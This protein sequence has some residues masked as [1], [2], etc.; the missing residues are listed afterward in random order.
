MK[1]FFKDIKTL[2]IL[3]LILIVLFLRFCS[4]TNP[5]LLPNP[6]PPVVVR[7]ETKWDTITRI[8]PIYTPKWETKT[9]YRDTTIY[10]DVDTSEILK[11]YFATYIYFDTLYNDSI[12][13]RIKDSISQNKIK[14]RIIEYDLLYPT[15]TITR[16]SIVRRRGFYAG[17][18]VGG[19]RNEF[20]YI[21]GEILY[22]NKKK[23]ALGIGVGV[24][25][26]FQPTF[27]GKLYWKL[28]K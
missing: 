28:G 19:T 17:V 25:Q 13:I 22:V 5:P 24:N 16:D 23:L 12:T 2:L 21:G 9:E 4:T 6:D 1:S 26:E 10:K 11:D 3:I 14:N 27:I 15:I 18:G 20:N 7:I 8:V